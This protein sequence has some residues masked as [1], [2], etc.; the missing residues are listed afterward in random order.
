MK[1]KIKKAEEMCLKKYGVIAKIT[2]NAQGYDL[3]IDE[4]IYYKTQAEMLKN[5][6]EII[7]PYCNT[8]LYIM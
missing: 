8:E 2:F 5:I 4:P 6:T 7:G 1:E 3:G